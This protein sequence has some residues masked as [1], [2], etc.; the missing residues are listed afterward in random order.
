MN[1]PIVIGIAIIIAFLIVKFVVGKI[2]KVTVLTVFI[3]GMLY[4]LSQGANFG[5]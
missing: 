1:E 4:V 5:L 3:L 2:L